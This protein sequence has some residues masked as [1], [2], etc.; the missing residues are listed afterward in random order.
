LKYVGPH[1]VKLPPKND[2]G[3]SLT[4]TF[5]LDLQGDDSRTTKN[6]LVFV[7]IITSYILYVLLLI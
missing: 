7:I 2:F 4:L 6:V 1:A 3:I 5:D